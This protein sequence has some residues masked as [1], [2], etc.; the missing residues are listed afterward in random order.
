VDYALD[1]PMY[2][3]YRNGRYIDA[4]GQSF[5]DFLAGRLP[6][7][8]GEKPRLEDWVDHL[9]TAFPEVRV[10]RFMEMRGADGGMAWRVTALP[11]LWAGL[12]YDQA[13]LDQAWQ[14]VKGWS[15]EERQALRDTVPRQALRATIAGRSV[16]AV[17]RDMLAIARAGLVG[18]NRLDA[19]GASEVRYLEPLEAMLEAGRTEAEVLLDAFEHSWAHDV[20]RVFQERR[21]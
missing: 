17:A 19:A 7:L 4:A 13:A 14:L 1:V 9:S 10:K 16:L 5:R 8:P 20:G 3:V 15:A 6:A 18:R 12:I 21:F 2:F 11:A